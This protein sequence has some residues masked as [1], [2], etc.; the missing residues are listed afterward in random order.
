MATTLILLNSSNTRL[1]SR[2]YKVDRVDKWTCGRTWGLP[3]QTRLLESFEMF[4]TWILQTNTIYKTMEYQWNIQIMYIYIYICVQLNINIH[5]YVYI[6]IFT[7]I[8]TS[9]RL[10][11]SRHGPWAERKPNGA[12]KFNGFSQSPDSSCGLAGVRGWA[13]A[14]LTNAQKHPAQGPPKGLVSRKF[15]V[16]I[17]NGF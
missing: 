8:N 12:L 1:I 14:T 17:R 10:L 7:Y 3:K 5:W 16:Q 11:Q 13:P 4:E 2:C 15:T 6:Y 9:Y